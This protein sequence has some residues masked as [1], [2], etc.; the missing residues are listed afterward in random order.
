MEIKVTSRGAI[1]LF[2]LFFSGLA[3]ALNWMP[4]TKDYDS[5]LSVL[6]LVPFLI[7]VFIILFFERKN[8][9]TI[10]AGVGIVFLMQLLGVL[11]VKI[12]GHWIIRTFLMQS[13]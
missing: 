3:M 11:V 8:I 1:G 9:P 12:A 10:A 6:D 2:L 13:T 7:G 4:E 5:L